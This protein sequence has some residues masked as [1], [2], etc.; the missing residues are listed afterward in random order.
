[1][2]KAFMAFCLPL[3]GKEA[4]N[5]D[6]VAGWSKYQKT[7]LPAFPAL[8]VRSA[9]AWQVPTASG[10]VVV[11]RGGLD[12]RLPS[13]CEITVSGAPSAPLR[14]KISE[15]TTCKGCPFVRNAQAS[16][17]E[18]GISLDKYDWRMPE[19]KA[20]LS[21]MTYALP[22][23]ADGVTFFVHVHMVR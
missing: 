11:S 14:K 12:E 8:K 16:K 4:T 13:S 20:L 15:A 5:T 23:R 18:A 22:E 2:E 1:V 10:R 3:V 9:P 17:D 21:V 19:K 6:E 7:T